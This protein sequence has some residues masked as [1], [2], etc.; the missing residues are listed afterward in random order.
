MQGNIFSY[1]EP[2]VKINIDF[3]GK[4]YRNA[5]QILLF[6]VTNTLYIKEESFSFFELSVSTPY[7]TIDHTSYSTMLN[8]L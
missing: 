4:V 3:L 8:Q 7:Y 1:L 5:V 6:H 2:T